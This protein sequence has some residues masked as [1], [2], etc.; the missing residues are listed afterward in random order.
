M[1]GQVVIEPG[2]PEDGSGVTGLQFLALR[3]V[4]HHDLRAWQVKGQEGLDILLNRHSSDR[5]EDRTGQARI[6]VRV[7]LPQGAELFGVDA[8]G[9]GG[10]VAKAMLGQF[11]AHGRRGHHQPSGRLVEPPHVGV[12]RRQG[13]GQAGRNVLGEACVIAGG[14]GQLPLHADPPGGQ[15]DGALG[16]DVDGLGL[17]GLEVLSHRLVGAD[18]DLDLGIGG[19]REAPELVR[20]D[21]LHRM[22]HPPHLVDHPGQGPDDPVHLWLPGVCRDQD[23]EL[24]AS[25]DLGPDALTDPAHGGP[26]LRQALGLQSCPECAHQGVASGEIAINGPLADTRQPRDLGEGGLFKPT[27]LQQPA[28]DVEDPGLSPRLL[29]APGETFRHVAHGL[30]GRC[31]ATKT[32]RR[33]MRWLQAARLD[34]GA[35]ATRP[36]GAGLGSRFCSRLHSSRISSPSSRSAIA[37]QLSTQS[38][39]LT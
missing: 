38:P 33:S 12:A 4:P 37:V 22:S 7:T 28:H 11:V 30:H 39:S 10:D 13:Q 1:C 25:I 34:S 23:S 24:P 29:L 36:W 8:P 16:G 35:L 2:A 20:R 5:Q 15:T 14:E 17:E 32:G 6:D 26:A 18:R 9:P 21:D 31:T 27:L 3:T 19:K